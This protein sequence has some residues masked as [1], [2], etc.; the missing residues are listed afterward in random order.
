MYNRDVTKRGPL[1]ADVW[2]KWNFSG[3][4]EELEKLWDSEYEKLKLD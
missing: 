4:L 1:A 3:S 2:K